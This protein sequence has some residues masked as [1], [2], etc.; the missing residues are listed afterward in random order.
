MQT[1]KSSVA[2]WA[3]CL[4]LGAASCSDSA[5]PTSPSATVAAGGPS[6]MPPVPT[7]GATIQGVVS[8]GN[9]GTLTHFAALSVTLTVKV[10]GTNISAPV[11][12]S[13][14]FVLENVPAGSVQL[15]FTGGTTSALSTLGGVNT[16]DRLDLR[17]RLSGTVGIV[18]ASVHIKVDNSTVVEGFVTSVSGGCPN[19]NF[20]VNGWTLKLDSS[21]AS[22]CTNIKVGIKVKIRGTVNSTKVVVV[23]RIETIGRERDDDDT[24]DGDSDSDRERRTLWLS[25]LRYNW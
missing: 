12:A 7:S 3:I 4:A 8:D 13:G 5:L 25:Q 17:I 18:E 19:L 21:S 14:A 9:A 16:G 10:V 1:F 2:I 6:A 11:S 20:V 23:I 24:D 15:Q 22:G